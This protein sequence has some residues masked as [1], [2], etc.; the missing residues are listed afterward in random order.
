MSTR[1]MIALGLGKQLRNLS[2]LGLVDRSSWYP[3]RPRG[4]SGEAQMKRLLGKGSAGVV[5]ARARAL[6]APAPDPR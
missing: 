6:A 1:F 3:S 4:R 5:A 2:G